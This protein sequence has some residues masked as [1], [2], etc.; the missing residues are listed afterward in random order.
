MI[1]NI[2]RLWLVA[3]TSMVLTGSAFALTIAGAEAEPSG[4][5][6][7]T[8]GD[9]STP[10][11]TALLSMAGTYTEGALTK[12]YTSDA[13][14]V[15]DG[16]GSLEVFG[17]PAA[18]GYT[19]YTPKVG[20]E[21]TGTGEYSPFHQIPE[22]EATFS[23]VS[24]SSSNNPVAP[25]A[26]TTIPTLDQN[27]MPL[28]VGEYMFEVDDVTI[29][30]GTGSGAS[31]LTA[32]EAFGTSNLQLTMT[33]SSD[34]S[35]TLYYYESSYSAPFVNLANMVIP[36]GPVDITGFDSVYTTGVPEFNIVSILPE[37]ASLGLMALG[38]I[39]MLA[40]RRRIA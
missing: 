6:G 25:P 23:N 4:T 37:P 12:T 10:V 39:S 3:A 17:T 5:T 2:S 14:L 7:V 11:V 38:G 16:T 20:D 1:K 31:T 33:D 9:V 24:S 26:V 18:L 29:S 30:S 35:M 13:F 22:L 19:T 15:N 32:G 34:N 28:T 21:F 36:T 27:P 40:R 8:I